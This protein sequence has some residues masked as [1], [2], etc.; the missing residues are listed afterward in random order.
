VLCHAG[1]DSLPCYVVVLLCCCV[2]HY[3]TT[4]KQQT[5]HSQQQTT[6][7]Q[8]TT[9]VQVDMYVCLSIKKLGKTR[10]CNAK[11]MSQDKLSRLFEW[12]MNW[13]LG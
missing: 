1:S 6:N 12:L 2:V 9:T 8:P 4:D 3:Q 11:M 5:G 7:K 13:C 10:K